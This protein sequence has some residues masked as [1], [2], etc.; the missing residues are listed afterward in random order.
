MTSVYPKSYAAW[1]RLLRPVTNALLKNQ[2]PVI[3]ELDGWT[4]TAE[5]SYR[6]RLYQGAG[7]AWFADIRAV[8]DGCFAI[9]GPRDNVINCFQ[10]MVRD[11]RTAGTIAEYQRQHPDWNGGKS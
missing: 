10:S 7:P 2:P 5:K 8:K 9:S 1:E 11:G 4:F 3:V 6:S